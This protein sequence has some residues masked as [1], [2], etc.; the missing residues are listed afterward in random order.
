MIPLF[1]AYTNKPRK[2]F[3]DAYAGTIV[4]ACGLSR[5]ASGYSGNLIRVRRSSDS[6][7]QDIPLKGDYLDTANLL[8]F[9]GASS[10]YVTKIYDQSGGGR[11]LVQAT[12]AK[13]PR[14]VNAGVLDTHIY[15]DQSDDFMATTATIPGTTGLTIYIEGYFRNTTGDQIICESSTNYNTLKGIITYIG[16]GTSTVL[17]MHNGSSGIYDV[18]NYGLGVLP[19]VGNR[20]AL[21]FDTTQTANNQSRAARSGVIVTPSSYGHLAGGDVTGNLATT[22]MAVGARSGSVLPSA[23]MLS[24]ILIFNSAHADSTVQAI[25]SL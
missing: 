13:Q 12:A 10:G 23:L 24:S 11:D 3:I 4:V 16:S 7:E 2:K 1:N 19:S 15:F 17:S 21:R 22:T 8:S 9:V 5:L 25:L 14:I 6:T 20:M 18:T